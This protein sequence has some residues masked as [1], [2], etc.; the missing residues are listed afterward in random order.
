MPPGITRRARSRSLASAGAVSGGLR[1]WFT[2]A[3]LVETLVYNEDRK[4]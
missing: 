1:V 2:K 3:P 4:I